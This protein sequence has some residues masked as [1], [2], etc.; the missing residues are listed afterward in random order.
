MINVPH[1]RENEGHTAVRSLVPYASAVA[2]LPSPLPWRLH[3]PA[4]ERER[5]PSGCDTVVHVGDE[6]T[7]RSGL[8]SHRLSVCIPYASAMIVAAS[9]VKAA[10]RRTNES[11]HGDATVVRQ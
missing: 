6:V 4:L 9:Y 8:Q 3:T 10:I 1:A 5:F 7:D 2:G 11:S